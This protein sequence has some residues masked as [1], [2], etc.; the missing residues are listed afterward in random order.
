M[1]TNLVDN[2]V[3]NDHREWRGGGRYGGVNGRGPGMIVSVGFITVGIGI[4]VCVCVVVKLLLK[5]S[6]VISFGS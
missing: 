6:F 5:W 3:V 2:I 4:V 1:F